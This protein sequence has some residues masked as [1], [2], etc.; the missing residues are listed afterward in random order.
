MR[1]ATVAATRP[2]FGRNDMNDPPELCKP[3][4]AGGPASGLLQA[5]VTAGQ[6]LAEANAA[7]AAIHPDGGICR[8]GRRRENPSLRSD[9]RAELVAGLAETGTRGL[10]CRRS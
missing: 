4:I 5:D 2:S 10:A 1:P 7:A 6:E 8:A 3:S 9:A